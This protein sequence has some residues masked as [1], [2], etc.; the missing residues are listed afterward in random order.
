MKAS[1]L[2]VAEVNAAAVE[3]YKEMRSVLMAA[4]GED[5]TWCEIVVTTQ[6]GLLGHEVPFKLHAKRL[7]ELSISKERLQNVVLAGVGVTFVLP[8]AALVLDWIDEAYQQYQQSLV[9]G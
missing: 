5:R 9:Q 3:R 7:F 6:L 8:Q 2:R 1:T 4:S